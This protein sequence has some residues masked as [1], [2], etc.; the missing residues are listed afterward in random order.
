GLQ[1]TSLA[2]GLGWQFPFTDDDPGVRRRGLDLARHSLHV[3][4][5]LGV[6]TLLVV[7]GTLAALDA[8]GGMHVPY[9][10]AFERMRA[11][12]GQLVPAAEEVGVVLGI[13]N[14]W[15][16]LLLSPLEM[17]D[18]IDGFGSD[19]VGSY[20]DVGNV[21]LFGYPEDWIRILGPRIRAVHFKDFKHSVGT[22][23]GFCDLL[24]G[25]VDYPAVTRALREVGY[26][27][28]CVAEFFGLDGA[29]LAALSRAMD[30]ILAM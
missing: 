17:R 6:E 26:D 16:R 9:D 7:P 15:N 13:E 2:S 4:S 30:K 23:E 1:L 14:V 25:D 8:S 10:V 27:G 18:F 20:F 22:L 19:A 29:A 12:I 5:W 11:A 24:E 21:V 3:A 28:P